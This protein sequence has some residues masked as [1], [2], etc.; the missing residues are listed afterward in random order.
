MGSIASDVQSLFQLLLSQLSHQVH[1][2]FDGATSIVDAKSRVLKELN[3]IDSKYN[4]LNGLETQSQQLAYFKKHLNFIVSISIINDTFYFSE[5]ILKWS[6]VPFW[7][8]LDMKE[9]DV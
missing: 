7:L 8:L 4:I 2:C 5:Y 6:L 3:C 9:G 1:S